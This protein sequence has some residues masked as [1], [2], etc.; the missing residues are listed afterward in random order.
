MSWY[1]PEFE[2]ENDTVIDDTVAREMAMAR[3]LPW[4]EFV[5]HAKSRG[6]ITAKKNRERLDKELENRVREIAKE[7]RRRGN[8]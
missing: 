1:T 7:T 4:R 3:D 2:W 6:L 8:L 5:A